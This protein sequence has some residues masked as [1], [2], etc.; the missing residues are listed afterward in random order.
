MA[1]EIIKGSDLMVFQ[2]GK[3]L[4][5]ATNCSLKLGSTT[6]SISSKDHGK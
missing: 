4:A 3:S 1:N 5:Y 6:A 2:G